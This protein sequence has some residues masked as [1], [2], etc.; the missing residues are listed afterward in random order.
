VHT[1]LPDAHTEAPTA[2]SVV[3]AGLLLKTGAYGILRFA[4]PLFP[5]ATRAFAPVAMALGALSIVYGAIMAFAQTDLKRLVAYTSVSH[6]GF[7][8]LGIY[9]GNQLA[10]QGVV[11]Q[12]ICH[13]LSTGGLFIIVGL[14]QERIHT[15]DITRMGGFAKVAPRMAGVALVIAM[16]GM[17]LPGLGNFV[18]EILTLVGAFQ[19]DKVWTIVATLGLV[20]ATLYSLVFFQRAFQGPAGSGARFPDLSGRET[21]ILGTL[22]AALVWLGWYPQPVLDVA[23]ASLTRIQEL[24]SPVQ[25]SSE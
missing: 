25:L 4:L 1:W 16:A 11:M 7:V 12:M 3:L 19:A 2:G 23:D 22:I 15:R 24:S 20:G 5:E 17:G 9:A 21:L 10:L 13:G 14:L 18:A 8:L 6:L